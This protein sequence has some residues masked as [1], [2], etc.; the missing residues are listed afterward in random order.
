MGALQVELRRR[1]GEADAEKICSGNA[2]RV[3]TNSWS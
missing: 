3:L 2:V 1:Y